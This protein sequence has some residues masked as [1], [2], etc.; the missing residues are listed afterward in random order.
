MPPWPWP[1]RWLTWNG[2]DFGP[3]WDVDNP[4]VTYLAQL[5]ARAEAAASPP[6][7]I[8]LPRKAGVST[9]IPICPR[10]RQRAE[11]IDEPANAGVGSRFLPAAFLRSQEVSASTNCA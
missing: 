3:M 9:E 5:K 8:C 1:R 10:D 6:G 7:R 11:V 2:S 4:V